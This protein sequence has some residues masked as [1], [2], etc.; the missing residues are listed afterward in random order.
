MKTKQWLTTID[1]YSV[2]ATDTDR[3]FTSLEIASQLSFPPEQSARKHT[4]SR[5]TRISRE[6]NIVSTALWGGCKASL[7]EKRAQTATKYEYRITD[8]GLLHLRNHRTK[9]ESME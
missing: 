8:K 4:G 1:Y 6:T 7:V 3:W 5:A 2:L 9:M